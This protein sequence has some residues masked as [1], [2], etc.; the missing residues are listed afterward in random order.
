MSGGQKEQFQMS[1]AQFLVYYTFTRAL[2]L[3]GGDGGAAANE[4]TC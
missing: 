3:S 2:Q 1:W 4:K